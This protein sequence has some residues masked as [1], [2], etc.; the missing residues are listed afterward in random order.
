MDIIFFFSLLSS[1]IDEEVV[2]VAVVDVDVDEAVV[3]VALDE[4]FVTDAKGDANCV[5]VTETVFCLG[6]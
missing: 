6:A 5:L 4:A 2:E 3:D 1:E